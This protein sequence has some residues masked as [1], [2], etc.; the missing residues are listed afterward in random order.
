MPCLPGQSSLTRMSESGPGESPEYVLRAE[1]QCSEG[2]GI[3]VMQRDREKPQERRNI[4]RG[5]EGEAQCEPERPGESRQIHEI[6]RDGNIDTGGTERHKE[7]EA[8]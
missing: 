7:T 2:L 5:G 4:G 6:E 3:V 8:H 1:G